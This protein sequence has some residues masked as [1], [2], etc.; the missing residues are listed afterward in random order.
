LT[1]E[2]NE[3]VT[4]AELY[5]A[6]KGKSRL[7]AFPQEALTWI[8]LLLVLL[9]ERSFFSLKKAIWKKVDLQEDLEEGLRLFL[10]ESL[11]QTHPEKSFRK[12]KLKGLKVSRRDMA[13]MKLS[14]SRILGDPIR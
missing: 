1:R 14:G 11:G 12:R 4:W 6:L 8:G 2:L 9:K 5:D 10:Q 7:K 13:T 3:G